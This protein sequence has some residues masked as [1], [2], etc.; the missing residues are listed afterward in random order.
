[1]PPKVVLDVR[2]MWQRRA[3]NA[4]EKEWDFQFDIGKKVLS[5]LQVGDCYF[6]VFNAKRGDFDYVSPEVEAVLGFSPGDVD[7]ELIV[8]NIHPEDQ[9]WFLNFENEITR[10]YRALPYDLIPHYKIRY[11]FRIRKSNNEYIRLLNQV[12]IV[13]HDTTFGVLRSFGVHTDITHLK[14]DGLP[15]L[16]FIG[17]NGHPSFIDV[18]VKEVYT[19]SL[20]TLTKRE[21]QILFLLFDGLS[22]KR[23]SQQLF[24]SEDTVKTHRKNIMRKTNSGNLATLLSNA[25]KHGW[26]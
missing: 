8:S 9:G 23:I 19:T 20:L 2:R 21:R 16:S 17:L 10:F 26:V 7:V 22:N 6:F 1:M 18:K 11:D 25:I 24:L 3:K 14:K 4:P 13:E 5:F 15:V 12:V